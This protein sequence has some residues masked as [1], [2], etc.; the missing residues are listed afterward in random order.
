MTVTVMAA[1]R[2]AILSYADTEIPGRGE[3]TSDSTRAAGEAFDMLIGLP[4]PLA[5]DGDVSIVLRP[6]GAGPT[7]IRHATPISPV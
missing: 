1:D 7:I 4:E 2:I 5:R 3:W 6:E